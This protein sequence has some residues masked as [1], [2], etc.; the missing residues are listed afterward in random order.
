MM[1]ICDDLMFLNIQSDIIAYN[2]RS[3]AKQVEYN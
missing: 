1:K 3:F 2:Q